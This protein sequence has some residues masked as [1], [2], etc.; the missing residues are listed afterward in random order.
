MIN[1]DFIESYYRIENEINS[2]TESLF[3]KQNGQL[4][5][6]LPIFTGSE[7]L[8]ANKLFIDNRETPQS[9]NLIIDQITLFSTNP[10]VV[11]FAPLKIKIGKN[12]EIEFLPNAVELTDYEVLTNERIINPKITNRLFSTPI[13]YQY[14]PENGVE[15]VVNVVRKGDVIYV[16]VEDNISG[17]SITG[18]S[19]TTGSI[20]NTV[21]SL[22][23]TFIAANDQLGIFIDTVAR[24][25]KSL[26][27]ASTLD[28]NVNAAF[29]LTNNDLIEELFLD[30]RN[31]TL[32]T[33]NNI[34]NVVNI[35]TVTY[36]HKT[37]P[38]PLESMEPYYQKSLT[39]SIPNNEFTVR[40]QNNLFFFYFYNANVLDIYRVG[41]IGLLKTYNN[42]SPTALTYTNFSLTENLAD[43]PDI[44]MISRDATR[45]CFQILKNIVSST[46]LNEFNS[47]IFLENT[48][49][50]PQGT[51]GQISAPLGRLNNIFILPQTVSANLSPYVLKVFNSTTLKISEIDFRKLLPT[52]PQT[53]NLTVDDFISIDDHGLS[54]VNKIGTAEFKVLYFKNVREPDKV[55]QLNYNYD[56]RTF[57]YGGSQDDFIFEIKL[58]NNAPTA[59]A[60]IFKYVIDL[61]VRYSKAKQIDNETKGLKEAK[62]NKKKTKDDKK[63]RGKLTVEKVLGYEDDPDFSINDVLK[64][65]IPS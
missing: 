2:K 63:K 57:L 5:L 56:E 64:L 26:E 54:I 28:I 25:V 45:T 30:G 44:V 7:I 20:V 65:Y 22:G 48:I 58:G 49:N 61:R 40:R 12:Q 60:E 34:T 24:K 27:F 10:N 41:D 3:Q 18:I 62:D 52:P 50:R 11:N 23:L 13:T 16:L 31:A 39:L 47:T 21:P 42:V 35:S 14:P 59:N 55:Y 33:F 17:Y 15:M 4:L 38:P 46:D 36:V 19:T 1:S 9:V 53:I 29:G 32:V 43:D 51:I 37:A 8:T 6:T